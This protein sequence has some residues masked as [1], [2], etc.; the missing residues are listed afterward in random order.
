MSNLD[1]RRGKPVMAGLPLRCSQPPRIRA[2][3]RVW[4][5]KPG[6]DSNL[7]QMKP[8]VTCNSGK[9]F[10]LANIMI[11]SRA[12][13]NLWREKSHFSRVTRGQVRQHVTASSHVLQAGAVTVC[14]S[15]GS[16]SNIN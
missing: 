14:G 5:K 9:A 1:Y 4:E 13:R 10:E 16:L 6:L 3:F 12:T 2:G 8:D 11:H 15:V 7:F